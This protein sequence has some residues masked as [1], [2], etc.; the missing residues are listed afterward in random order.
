MSSPVTVPSGEAGGSGSSSGGSQIKPIPPSPSPAG[1]GTAGAGA[2]AATPAASPGGTPA[3]ADAASEPNASTRNDKGQFVSKPELPGVHTD[4]KLKPKPPEPGK[5]DGNGGKGTV[6]LPPGAP[7]KTA[8]PT[9]PGQPGPNKFKFGGKEWDSTE[10]AEQNFR[11]LQGMHRSL[12]QRIAQLDEGNKQNHYSATQ[13]KTRADQLQARLDALEKG[14]PTGQEAGKAGGNG[15]AA[16]AANKPAGLPESADD[17]LKDVDLGLVEEIANE[18]GPLVAAHYLYKEGTTRM[19]AAM[20][21]ELSRVKQPF[22]QF[23]GALQTA[24]VTRTMIEELAGA[25]A[26]GADGQPVP[27]YPELGDPQAMQAI[28][29][30]WERLGFTEE[31]RLSPLALT[32][33]ILHFR[34]MRGLL[35]G[36]GSGSGAG[37]ASTTTMTLQAN[38]AT[39]AAAAVTAQLTGAPANDALSGRSGTAVRPASG[40]ESWE[41]RLR[42]EVREAPGPDPELGFVKRRRA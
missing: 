27:I 1:P 11:T 40:P 31:A 5:G 39:Q 42:R 14:Q 12:N 30:I 38:G 3:G 23:H 32:S 36:G 35:N 15:T 18:R 20:R 2:A 29:A 26:P 7:A 19:L 37:P 21:E 41:D 4:R 9:Q 6:P 24:Q 33:A 8:D 17:L 16:G 28:S 10:A 25:S 34:N 22:E 13:W